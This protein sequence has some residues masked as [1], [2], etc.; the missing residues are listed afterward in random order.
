M[1]YKTF[2]RR[3]VSTGLQITLSFT[4][5]HYRAAGVG[6]S[7]LRGLPQLEAYQLVNRLNV[8]QTAHVYT[9]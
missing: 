4:E 6:Y 9:L 8:E 2:T 1:G 5:E 7:P 3:S